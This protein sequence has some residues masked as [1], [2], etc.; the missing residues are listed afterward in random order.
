MGHDGADIS[1]SVS[2][3]SILETGEYSDLEIHCKEDRYNVHKAIVCPQSEVFHRALRPDSGFKRAK[4]SQSG[5]IELHEADPAVVKAMVQFLYRRDYDAPELDDDNNPAIFHANNYAAA[6]MYQVHGLKDRALQHFKSHFPSSI[7]LF[8][9]M[10]D[11]VYS[12]TLDQD[13]SLRDYVVEQVVRDMDRF[14]NLADL[15]LAMEEQALFGKDLFY[16]LHDYHITRLKILNR[17]VGRDSI[18]PNCRKKQRV[19]S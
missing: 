14:R 6:E 1:G 4:E 2:F 7:E 13:R 12:T 15:S 18:C 8:A 9:K 3:L 16:G 19:A 11:T 17:F 10:I 5:V